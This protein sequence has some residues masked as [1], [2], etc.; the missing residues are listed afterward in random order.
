M[1]TS[2]YEKE[3]TLRVKTHRNS[4]MEMPILQSCALPKKKNTIMCK[5][6]LS[7]DFFRNKYISRNSQY[8]NKIVSKCYAVGCNPNSC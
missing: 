3:N 2:F 1:F 5:A 8:V 6:E 7:V 4:D